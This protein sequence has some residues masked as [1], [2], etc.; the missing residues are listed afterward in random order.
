MSDGAG[1]D[2]G[3][4]TDDEGGGTFEDLGLRPELLSALAALGYE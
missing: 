4:G 1:Q 3:I 2:T